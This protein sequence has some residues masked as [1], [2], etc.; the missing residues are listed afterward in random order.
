[1]LLVTDDDGI[2]RA[3]EFADH[4]PRMHRLLHDHYGEI[5]LQNAAAPKSILEALDAYFGGE[6]NALDKLP[7]AT[8]GTKFQRAVWRAL[9]SIP[10]GTTESYGALATR[11]GRTGS[12][13]AVGA[14]NGANPIAIVVPCHRVIG[15]DG[16][17]TGYGG[18]LARKRWLLD[19]EREYL[20]TQGVEDPSG[21][22]V[23]DPRGVRPTRIRLG[24]LRGQN[25]SRQSELVR[26]R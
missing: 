7:T 16:T 26:G 3:L 24:R 19:H 18:G 11:L 12:G 4:E 1:L 8:G 25:L 20:N 10:A 5:A 14:A 6:L 2:L 21:K 13:R 9:R 23:I 22:K 15:A 17:L